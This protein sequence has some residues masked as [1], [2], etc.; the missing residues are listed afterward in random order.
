MG[1]SFCLVALA[2]LVSGSGLQARADLAPAAALRAAEEKFKAGELAQALPLYRTAAQSAIPSIRRR[3]SDQV[4]EV[5]AQLD[6]HVQVVQYGLGYRAWLRDQDESGRWREVT[7]QIGLSY[8]ALGQYRKAEA[9]LRTALDSLRSDSKPG[10]RR[11]PALA[12]VM[13]LAQLARIAE[14][15]GDTKEAE[16]RWKRTEAEAL[17]ELGVGTSR[18]EDRKQIDCIWQL[19]ESYRF[20]NRHRE[21]IERLDHALALAV[22]LEDAVARS[23]T[24][25]RLADH[26]LALGQKERGEK[27]MR[28]GVEVHAALAESDPAGQADL[29]DALGDVLARKRETDRTEAMKVRKEA[30]EYYVRALEGKSTRPSSRSHAFWKLH[31][32]FQK[33]H[34]YQRALL[35][36]EG[37][38]GPGA[39]PIFRDTRLK[40]ELGSLHVFLGSYDE[41]RKLLRTALAAQQETEPLNLIEL[42]R[43]LNSLAIVEQATDGLDTAEKLGQSVVELYRDHK[44]PDDLVLVEAYNVLGTNCA[45]RG[46]FAQGVERFRAG[47]ERC[48]KLGSKADYILSS[49]L[50]NQALLHKAQAEPEE[51]RRLCQEAMEVYQRSDEVDPLGLALFQCALASLHAEVGE[52]AQAGKLASLVLV[53]C[54]KYKITG[55]PLRLTAQ[56][57]RALHLLSRGEKD[58]ARELWEEVRAAQ[59]KGGQKLFLPRTLTY[60]GLTAELRGREEEARELYDRARIVHKESAGLVDRTRVVPTTHFV[61]LWRAAVLQDRR[62]E[63]TAAKKTLLEAIELVEA[64]RLRTY[65]DSLQ[66]TS[67]FAQFVPGF[68][69]SVNWALRDGQDAEAFDLAARSRSRAFLDQMLLAGADPRDHLRGE[70]GA[71]LRKKEREL[72]EKISGLRTHLQLT[73]PEAFDQPRTRRLLTDLEKAQEE[74]SGTWREIINANPLY[75]SLA[76]SPSVTR[77]LTTLRESVLG[78]RT[79]LLA[80]HLQRE[81]AMVFLV[82][83]GKGT[84]EVFS[85]E[86][87]VDFLPELERDLPSGSVVAAAKNEEAAARRGI[88]VRRRA[89]GGP[90]SPAAPL[91]PDVKVVALNQAR[92]RALVEHYRAYLEDVDFATPRG[93]KVV[94][95]TAEGE[96][97]LR[98][99]P[100]YAGILLPPALRK[101]LRELAPE[102]I[103]VIP[104]GPLHKLPLEALVLQTEPLRFALDELPPLVYAPSA[105]SVAW[106]SGRAEPVDRRTLGLVTVSDPA[107]PLPPPGTKSAPRPTLLNLAL[108]RGLPRLPASAEESRRVRKLFPEERTIHLEGSSASEARL[109]A[110][111]KSERRTVLHIAAHGFADD[112]FGNLFGAVALTPGTKR[113]GSPARSE[114]DG[115]LSLY[116]IYR[117]DLSRCELA[118]LSA[119]ETNVGP[120]RPLEAGLTLASAFLAAGARRVV[121][122][123]WNVDDRS[124]AELMGAFFEEVMAERKGAFSYARALHNARKKLREQP[125]TDAPF[126]WAPFVLIGAPESSGARKAPR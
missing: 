27:F 23:G 2:C 44:L 60:L 107:Y 124:T 122:S 75:R 53:Q 17:D 30:A 118:V 120:Q 10:A 86:V 58:T 80:Y 125:K 111:L 13:A 19:A 21:A 63:R 41:A 74:F 91:S 70:S 4:L 92:A 39:D 61:S 56:H 93:L 26:Y 96:K 28:Q 50:L 42:P 101:R 46:R 123:H 116:E 83:P 119:C 69:Q 77:P 25:R 98:G 31:R 71:A 43:T 115:Y 89:E 110:A 36:V 97:A 109:V 18:L 52:Y 38:A 100:A 76:D 20:Q 90:V 3:A 12:R 82:P 51:A 94:A 106:L 1:R 78:E 8:L 68:E 48:R 49:L 72:L 113:A 67:F 85:L 7:L 47:V 11:L 87:P 102:E 81:R 79:A 99:L 121:A 73:A 15:Q 126:Q 40:A 14:I 65:G 55:G 114:D 95:R 57:C 64:V 5:A 59:E 84:P 88:A 16:Q 105:S 108:A 37:Q 66:R 103:V 32:L 24:L 29:L 35:L 54:E 34:Q 9:D 62:G 33:T 104:D 45:L 22:K 112:R 117:L 6:Q